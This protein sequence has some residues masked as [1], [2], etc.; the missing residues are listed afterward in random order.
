[1]KLLLDS[2][3]YYIS[4]EINQNFH[5]FTINLMEIYTNFEKVN[6]FYGKTPKIH[7]RFYVN[8]RNYTVYGRFLLINEILSKLITIYT[9]Y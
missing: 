3:Y 1:M 6:L 9:L 2:E 4:Y 7:C 8:I 5:S